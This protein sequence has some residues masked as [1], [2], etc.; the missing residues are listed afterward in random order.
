MNQGIKCN[1]SRGINQKPHLS[2]LKAQ[3]IKQVDSAWFLFDW[4]ENLHPHP[5][6]F[7]SLCG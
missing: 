3:L 5:H 6:P 2:L 7:P 4:N 1:E